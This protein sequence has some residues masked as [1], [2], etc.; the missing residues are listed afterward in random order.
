MSRERVLEEALML[1]KQYFSNPSSWS[2]A[3]FAHWE[4]L[5]GTQKVTVGSLKDVVQKALDYKESK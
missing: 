2:K 3:Q 4:A 5:T 1:T